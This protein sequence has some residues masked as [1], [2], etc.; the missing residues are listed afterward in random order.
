MV[1]QGG[2][3]LIGRSFR[4]SDPRLVTA[5]KPDHPA[6]AT[7]LAGLLFTLLKVLLDH[8]VQSALNPIKI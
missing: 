1:R 8:L 5:P 3:R 6:R 2:E 4:N 7:R